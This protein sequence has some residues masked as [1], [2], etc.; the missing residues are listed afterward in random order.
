MTR[1]EDR[2]RQPH[3]RR[4]QRALCRHA[5]FF[6]ISTLG[7]PD[8]FSGGNGAGFGPGGSNLL[9]MARIRLMRGDMGKR[10]A[11]IVNHD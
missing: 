11:A 1:D 4:K 9:R 5:R 3:A 7:V 6:I 2:V 8:G 10:S